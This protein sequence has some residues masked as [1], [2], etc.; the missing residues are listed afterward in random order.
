MLLGASVALVASDRWLL[1]FALAALAVLVAGTLLRRTARE[2]RARARA[3]GEETRGLRRSAG[4]LL[5]LGPVIGFATSPTLGEHALVAV[6]GALA[7]AVVGA[8]ADRR[9]D[10]DRLV[11]IAVVATAAFAVAT[12]VSAGPT[13]VGVVDVLLTLAVL[14]L[15]TAAAN[16]L[17]N[18]EGLTPAFGVE[19]ALGVFA[20][21]AFAHQDSL[22]AVA[23][24]LAG[25]C[26]AFLA[27]NLRPASLF[28]GRGGRLAVGY[29]IAVGALSVDLPIG[30]A[31]QLLVPAILLGLLLLDGV[32]VSVDR[33]RR[34]QSLVAARRDH[35]VHRLVALR[36][37]TAE[38]IAGLLLAQGALVLVAVLT[39]RGVLA[40]WAGVLLGGLVVGAIGVE[41]TRGRL[42]QERPR[43][44]PR[45]ARIAV[46]TGAALLA[47]AALPAVLVVPDVRDFMEEGRSAAA[48]G[49]AAA[50]EGD[51]ATAELG[52]RR[53]A[54]AFQQASDKVHGPL[55]AGGVLV[56]GLASNLHAAQTLADIGLDL[57]RSGE[58]VT[59]AVD[60][61]SLEV[62]DGRLPLEEVRRVTPALQDGS[63][64]LDDAL[65]KLEGLDD[66]YLLSVVTEARDDI[67]HQLR[68]AAKEARHAAAAARLA[69]VIFGGD[70]TRRYLLIVQNNAELR[71]TG[72]LIGN[73]GLLTASDGDVSIGELF[74]PSEWNAALGS[75]PN[76]VVDTPPGHQRRFPFRPQFSMQDAN[77]S[78][79]FPTAARILTSLAPQVGVP[80]LDG[81][82]AVDPLGL[83]ALLELTGP[84]RVAGWP[85]DITASN[86]VDVTLR[87]QYARFEN[88]PGRSE[89]LGDVARKVIDTATSTNLGSPAQIAKVL[90]AAAHE[91]HIQLAFTHPKEQRLAR[92]LDVA[93]ELAP[94][95][96]DALAVNTQNAA[97]N[98]IDYYLGRRIEYRV[99]LDPDPDRRTARVRARLTIHLENTAP[100]TGLPRIVIGPF[101]PSYVAGVNRSLVSVYSPLGV[102]RMTVDGAPVEF[103]ASE[104]AG[105]SVYSHLV[106]IPAKGTR[107]VQLDLTGRVRLRPGGWYELTLDHQP[108]IEPDRVQTSV[109][110]PEGWEV[111][112][113][114]GMAR[115]FDRLAGGVTELD[116]DRRVRVQVAPKPPTLNLWERLEAGT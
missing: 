19:G 80:H 68:R 92:E 26:L 5:V 47:L 30:P 100:D 90:G 3:R 4:V 8:V 6:L 106:E 69:P 105:R 78:E 7:L 23:A 14:T 37:S 9:P 31:G 72:G 57:A 85:E 65:A 66:P 18:T 32:I 111:A 84:V 87:D 13:G 104:E 28:A 112:E 11:A 45:A 73:W 102:D 109:R 40:V 44:L 101:D 1:T 36:W 103:T 43:G 58:D 38:A 83:A 116:R 71:A 113:A 93:G 34:R 94:V 107:T 91:G 21:A 2:A 110:V 60:P 56:P 50:R 108:T 53:A 62:V 16:G 67:S 39:G 89:F 20:L 115:P 25:A 17:G 63:R 51:A 95:R 54:G 41:A 24:G 59:T 86:V 88:Q 12:G 79:D 35:L 46:G 81:V 98:K 82:L 96:S 77:L 97:A 76:P 70:G 74:E 114:P 27:F 49:L 29:V 10:G 61:T 33:A 55:L 64:A 42:E 15:A 48:R 52:F 75:V 22:A 99:R